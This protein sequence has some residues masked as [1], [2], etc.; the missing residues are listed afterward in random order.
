MSL[1]GQW[2]DRDVFSVVTCYSCGMI[3][4]PQ[5]F[6]DH[7]KKRHSFDSL[8]DTNE[9]SEP[10]VPVDTVFEHKAKR[11]KADKSPKIQENTE[12]HPSGESPTLILKQTKK[13]F[14][15]NSLVAQKT[16]T[17]TIIAQRPKAVRIKMKLKKSNHGSWTVVTA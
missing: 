3:L 13:F 17:Q 4:K 1:Y 10:I 15:A 7:L 2:Q 11:Y 6:N 5:A 9:L 8:S 12:S 14:K 16:S